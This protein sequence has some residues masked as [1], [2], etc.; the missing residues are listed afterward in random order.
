[1]S[2]VRSLLTSTTP[3]ALQPPD[4]DGGTAAPPAPAAPAAV[5][6]IESPPIVPAQAPAAAAPAPGTLAAPPPAPAAPA[7]PPVIPAASGTLA[8]AG[9]TPPVTVPAKFPDTWRD[10]L[11]GGDATFRKTLD[12]FDSPTALAKSYRELATKLSSG[13]LKAPPAPLPDNAT[14]EQVTAWRAEQ[15][16]P[17]DAAAYVTGLQLPGGVVPGEADKPLLASFAQS[18]MAANW[19]AAQYNQA[20]GWYYGLQDQLVAERQQADDDMWME[21]QTELLREWGPRFKANQN[22]FNNWL[23]TTFPADLVPAVVNARLPDGTKMFGHPGVL[24][25]VMEQWQ[26]IN[27]VQSALP[28]VPGATLGNLDSRI[29]EIEQKYMRASPGSAEWK[30]YWDKPMQEEYR[31]LLNARETTKARQTAA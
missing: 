20:V 16:L 26:T 4:A 14:P 11:A 23:A 18:A 22:N 5:P 17:K 24:K 13:E 29:S 21:T 3:F 2:F 12:R 28:N 30:T 25:A 9:E 27:P 6:A 15:G 19:T 31:G 8:Q 1:M 10:D 7:A